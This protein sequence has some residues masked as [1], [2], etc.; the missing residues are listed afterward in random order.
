MLPL[1]LAILAQQP[2]TRADAAAA[3]LARGARV[4]LGRADTIAALGAARTARAFPNPTVSGSYTKDTP[5]YHLLSDLPLDLPWLRA[6]RIGAAEAARDA[7]R[8]QFAFDRAGILF[9]VDTTYTRALATALHGRLSRRTADDAD[10]LLKIARLRR[11][12]GDVSELDVRLAAVN[13]G[14]LQNAAIDDS[15]IALGTLLDLQLQMGLA[16]DTPA[17]VLVDSLAAPEDTAPPVTEG[18][19]MPGEYLPVAAAAARLRSAER[20]LSFTRASRFAPSVEFG[21]DKGDPASARPNELLPVIGFSLPFPLFNRSGGEVTRAAAERDRARAALDLTR[22]ET[23]AAVA[24]ARRE[25]VAARDRARRSADLVA[26]ANRIAAMSIQAY[27]E[28]AVAL[29]NVLEAQ[30]NARE[31]LAS[32]IDDL[33]A[34]DAALRALRW[35]TT[36]ASVR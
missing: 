27:G 8:S 14:Q 25:L 9:D 2:V 34:A 10:S 26:S 1:V 28:G 20:T 22:R 15:L 30:R 29:A 24:R 21:V 23:D 17:I 18:A 11:D 33:A 5:N 4:A 12:V 16:G 36:T 7:A 6:P 32:Y 3:A 31:I 13:A 35:L 19:T